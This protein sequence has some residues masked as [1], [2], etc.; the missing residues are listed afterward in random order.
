MSFSP[1]LLPLEMWGGIECTINRVGDTY[2]DQLERNG[3]LNRPGDLQRFAELGIRKIRYPI[4]WERIAPHGLERADWSWA[5]ERL[6]LLRELGITPI[7][8]LTHH[9]SGPRSTSLV[10]PAFPQKLAQFA[11]AVAQR[12]P[13]V[14]Y[15]TPVN[16]PLTTARFSGLYGLWYPHGRDEGTFVR[17]LVNQCR[18]VMLSMQAIRRINPAAQLIQTEDLGKAFSSP[19]LRRQAAWENER[20]WLSFDLLCG[21]LDRDHLMWEYLVASGISE[22][23]LDWFLEHPCPPDVMGIDYYVTSERFLDEHYERYPSQYHADNGKQKYADVEVVRVDTGS[24]LPVG[25]Y[26]RLCE[27]WERY[28]RPLAITEAHLGATRDE[29]I[30]WLVEAWGACQKLRG[31][32]AQVH[33]VTAWSLLGAYDW[34]TLVTRVTDFYESGVFDVRAS[35]P[36]PTAL[37]HIVRSLASGEEPHHPVLAQP[38]WWKRPHRFL[39]HSYPDDLSAPPASN[40]SFA[41]T[42]RERP[43]LIVGGTEKLVNMFALCCDLRSLPYRLLTQQE[44]GASEAHCVQSTL[45]KLQP[46]AVLSLIGSDDAPLK[47]HGSDDWGREQV[48]AA[49]LI[50]DACRHHGSSL[51]AF[52]SDAVFDGMRPAPYLESAAV[53]PVCPLG[54]TQAQIEKQT[55]RRCPAALLVR[56]GPLFGPWGFS[57]QV[58]VP[59]RVVRQHIGVTNQTVVSPTYVPDMVDACL[60]LLV[61]G[62]KGYWHLA[63][64]GSLKWADFMYRVADTEH[65]QTASAVEEPHARQPIAFSRSTLRLLHSEHGQLLPSLDDALARYAKESGGEQE[66]PVA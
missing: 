66:Q 63:N 33:A 43:L 28:Q 46:W 45:E 31:E 6:Q 37:A 26:E 51:L 32:G 39:Y 10:E 61:D 34:N 13:W 15:Y 14:E 64:L 3:H 25:H 56:T 11:A 19:L 30:R 7:V 16:E 22:Q 55:L 27:A 44:I 41:V 20:R 4:Q 29:Q 52:S 9:G 2:F 47:A 53:A 65:M 1:P 59:Q 38:G 48:R 58:S 21:C 23:E 35:S 60:D 54:R 62:E 42:G 57:R 8:G 24:A 40:Q 36:R 50:A 17:A 18:A 5:D 12:Y 49:A